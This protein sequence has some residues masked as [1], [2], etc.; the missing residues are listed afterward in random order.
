MKRFVSLLLLSATVLLYGCVSTENGTS[1]QNNET[2]TSAEN[3]EG[4][5]PSETAE[6][7]SGAEIDSKQEIAYETEQLQ[8]KI[9]EDG[10]SYDAIIR[11]TNTGNT[12]LNIGYTTFTIEDTDGKI[13][14]LEDSSAVYAMPTVLAPGES[15]YYF[16]ARI[17]LPDGLDLSKEYVLK[18]SEEYISQNESDDIMDFDVQDVSFPEGDYTDIIG[19][20]QNPDNIS[21]EFVDVVFIGYDSDHN[22]VLVEGTVTSLGGDEDGEFEI[23]NPG[24]YGIPFNSI[25]EYEII[26]RRNPL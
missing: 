10:T 4:D 3:K 21:V 19:R 9:S 22:V 2:S 25:A 15:G 14:A 13:I 23:Y 24:A 11:I 8:F 26:A 17:G 5:S 7:V 20:V 1:S 16:G 6:A 12:T 18:Y